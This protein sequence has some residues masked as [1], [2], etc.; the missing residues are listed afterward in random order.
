MSNAVG[1]VGS[2]WSTEIEAEDMSPSDYQRYQMAN[3]MRSHGRFFCQ[4]G[5]SKI[6]PLPTGARKEMV[7]AFL[8]SVHRHCGPVT[9]WTDVLTIRDDVSV[10][11]VLVMGYPKARALNDD[12]TLEV[13]R[14][15][16]MCDAPK[17]SASKLL[18]RAERVAKA[19][20]YS[21]LISYTLESEDGVSYAAAGWELDDHTTLGHQWDTK[22]RPRE[23]VDEDV[24]QDKTR[25]RKVFG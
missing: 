14:L 19:K 21:Q 4:W 5:Q 17:N 20:G 6:A 18:G 1:L 24:M 9:G 7:N 3:L 12:Q 23:L 25:W 11:G 22:S 2:M 10:Y 15:A 16:L 8:K 13:N